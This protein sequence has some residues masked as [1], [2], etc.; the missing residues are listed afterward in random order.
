MRFLRAFFA[1][2]GWCLWIIFFHRRTHREAVKRV[3]EKNPTVF[4]NDP[5]LA[6]V[7]VFARVQDMEDDKYDEL[8]LRFN[9]VR[10]EKTI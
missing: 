10:K 2:S 4:T 6:S 3:F 1:L 9:A 5:D 8:L 7:L